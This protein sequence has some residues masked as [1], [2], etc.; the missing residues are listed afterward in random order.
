MENLIKK[1]ETKITNLESNLKVMPESMQVSANYA[2]KAYYEIIADLTEL[3]DGKK[4]NTSTDSVNVCL[5]PEENRQH[6]I[7]EDDRCEQCDT[8][9]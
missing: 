1:Y 8:D 5:H 4:D 7:N 3:C 2:I 6:N 9:L